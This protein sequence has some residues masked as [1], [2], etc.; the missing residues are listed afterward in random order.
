MITKSNI[1]KK[2]P[3]PPLI[4]LRDVARLLS[5]SRGTLSTLIENG[6]LTAFEINPFD[7]KERRHLRV[8]RKSLLEFYKKRFGHPLDRDLLNPFDSESTTKN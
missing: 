1:P 8:T 4:R 7:E 2:D 5:I 6:E 3:V